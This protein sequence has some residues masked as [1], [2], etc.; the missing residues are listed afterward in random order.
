MDNNEFEKFYKFISEY[1]VGEE[2][3]IKVIWTGIQAAKMS[4]TVPAFLLRGPPGAGKTFITKLVSEYFNSQ[5]I[6]IQTTLNTSE[7]ELIYKYLP[8]ET[9]KSG[10]KIVYGPLP[11]ALK[12]SL[13]KIT[14]LTI[15]EFDKTRPSADSLLLDY[16]QNTRITFRIDDAED[17]IQGNPNNL[18]IFLTS[19]ENREFS[20]PLLRRVIT[21][22][23]KLPSPKAV[24]E[25]LEKYFNDQKI[26]KVLINIYAASI[27][28]DLNKP[29]T[30]QELIQFGYAL[31]IMPE[32]DFNQLLFSF[33]VK[34]I[35]DMQKLY[36]ALRGNTEQQEENAPDVA[37]TLAQHLD[38]QQ[39]KEEQE[40][41]HKGTN[42]QDILAHIKVPTE[43][44]INA[45][46]IT[47][48]SERTF[49]TNISKDFN[50]YS[51][52][53]ETF[54]PEPAERPDVLGKFNVVQ[55]ETELKI[56]ASTPLS[57]KEIHKL[58]ETAMNFEAYTE[59]DL[60][61]QDNYHGIIGIVKQNKLNIKYYSKNLVIAQNEN[62]ILRL[63]KI[64]EKH[65]SMKM[66]M[67]YTG[68]EKQMILQLLS[69][70][71]S[72]VLKEKIENL[73]WKFYD[74]LNGKYFNTQEY[75]DL[76]E[77]L[78]TTGLDAKLIIAM[79][80]QLY[81]AFTKENEINLVRENVTSDNSITFIITRIDV[82]T[83]KKEISNDIKN[84][85]NK[86]CGEYNLL[87]GLS[88]LKNMNN[89]IQ[90]L[91]R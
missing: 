62:I 86:Y 19:N 10:I 42:V 26:I 7:D 89:E 74:I 38:E 56:T 48:D 70:Q 39:Q 84:I 58:A 18:I 60:Y 51:K 65:F 27:H 22:D 75:E 61:F 30:I 67:K 32:A 76:A 88:I 82:P 31:T 85:V 35:N 49:S 14:V 73:R 80:K 25:I 77:F 46:K 81:V 15:D 52:V 16:I 47:E 66:Y 45:E 40:E 43:E 53:I 90:S 83:E 55:D 59:D 69:H 33:V 64:H 63:E 44:V 13:E 28:A 57:L 9:S 3:E 29:V 50:E 41:E 23:F 78:E 36:E 71:I 17:V 68:R 1:L 5:Y 72:E 34:N 12:S 2:E 91:M 6:F 87:E 37:Q 54:E 21:V 24:K 11:E 20:E 79:D 8:S 4:N